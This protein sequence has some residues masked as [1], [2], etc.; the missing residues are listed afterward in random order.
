MPSFAPASSFAGARVF[1][2]E[3]EALIAMELMDRLPHMGFMPC[4]HARTGEQ[5]LDAVEHAQADVVLM[6]VNLGDG[7]DGV[8]TALRI[9]RTHDVPVVFL[10]AYSDRGL[11]ARVGQVDTY[12]YVL[13]PYHD[14]ELRAAL[15]LAVARHLAV[16]AMRRANR[17]LQG[18]LARVQHLRGILPICMHCKQIRDVDREWHQLEAYI[19]RH[20]DALF[21]HTYCPSCYDVARKELDEEEAG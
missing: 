8:D 9:Q 13:K 2:V 1:V 16:G 3:D 12:G 17:E 10:T 5:A 20:S 15:S 11:L 6:D 18:A 19:S 14:D 4:G 7:I 21:S